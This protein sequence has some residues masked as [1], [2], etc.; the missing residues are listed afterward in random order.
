MNQSHVLRIPSAEP[1]GYTETMFEGTAEEAIAEQKRLARIARGEEGVGLEATE[2]RGVFDHY[3]S[4]KSFVGDEIMSQIG[5]MS[6]EQK[7]C[8]NEIKK[9]RARNK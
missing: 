3:M 8:M 4:G 5:R 9:W 6:G 1:Y 2:W 7:F